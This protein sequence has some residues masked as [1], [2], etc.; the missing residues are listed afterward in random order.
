MIAG[1]TVSLSSLGGGDSGPSI[2][3][4]AAFTVVPVV[5]GGGHSL[6]VRIDVDRPWLVDSLRIVLGGGLSVDAAPG[7][8]EYIPETP[9]LVCRAEGDSPSGG[10]FRLRGESSGPATFD[11]TLV[12]RVGDRILTAFERGSF[13][14]AG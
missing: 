10:A 5:S 1:T 6:D 12:A 9:V 8:W 3:P 13:P 2:P 7:G 4:A 14:A 11:V